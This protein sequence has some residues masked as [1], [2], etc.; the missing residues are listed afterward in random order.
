MFDCGRLVRLS[1]LTPK[2]T[3]DTKVF[4]YDSEFVLFLSIVVR[5]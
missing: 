5:T 4:D 3:T 2:I 1:I